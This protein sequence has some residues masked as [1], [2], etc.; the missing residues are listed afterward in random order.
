MYVWTVHSVVPYWTLHYL[1]C[2]PPV[3][4]TTD[5]Y[6]AKS[7]SQIQEWETL[8]D[9]I[10]SQ[11]FPSSVIC[12]NITPA[13]S[14][15]LWAWEIAKVRSEIFHLSPLSKEISRRG[16][17]WNE[18][19]RLKKAVSVHL[20]SF[21][22]SVCHVHRMPSQAQQRRK[23]QKGDGTMAEDATRL[24]SLPGHFQQHIS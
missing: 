20:M 5:R 12:W 9:Y 4:R 3:K 10:W 19:S 11:V 15:H 8:S 2:Q 18:F 24:P 16:T 1:L 22:R 17:E 23:A 7:Q 14:E 6:R 21:Q 13:Q